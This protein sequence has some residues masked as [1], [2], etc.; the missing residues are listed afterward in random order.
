MNGREFR[1]WREG[2]GLT[3]PTVAE[4]LGKSRRTIQYWEE[5]EDEPLDRTILYACRW[6]SFTLGNG[7][8]A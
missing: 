1:K 2:L 6:L 4:I 3:Q 8:A 7:L 5:N